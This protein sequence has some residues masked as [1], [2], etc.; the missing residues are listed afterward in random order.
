MIGGM[1]GRIAD[2]LNPRT[3]KG[4]RV[5]LRAMGAYHRSDYAAALAQFDQAMSLDLLRTDEHMAFKTVLLV[6]NN[7]PTRER[8]DLYE[9]V[10]AGEFR[11]GRKASKYARAYAGYWL[12]SATHRHDLVKAWS[13]A[14]ALKPTK[15][16]AA[17]YL[18]LPESPLLS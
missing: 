6:L 10:L 12:A 4:A 15:G 17:R 11:P 18:P 16:F 13:Q 1:R 3:W 5:F 2:L 8:L 7:R 14:H 9:R